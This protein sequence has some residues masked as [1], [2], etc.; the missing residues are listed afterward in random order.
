MHYLKA[1]RVGPPSGGESYIRGK[2]RMV[3]IRVKVKVVFS[4]DI[5]P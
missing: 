4:L 3:P 1:R 5:H 2:L